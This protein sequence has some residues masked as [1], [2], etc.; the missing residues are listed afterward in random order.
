MIECFAESYRTAR[1]M[2]INVYILVDRMVSMNSFFRLG[3]LKAIPAL[4]ETRGSW[5]PP[6]VLKAP[7]FSAQGQESNTDP[8][9]RPPNSWFPLQCNGFQ[10]PSWSAGLAAFGSP[11]LA[12]NIWNKVV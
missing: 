8:E 9:N 10:G 3:L 12:A 4:C 1:S 5:P 2:R 7:Q 11:N 6:A